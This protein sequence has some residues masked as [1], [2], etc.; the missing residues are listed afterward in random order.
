MDFSPDVKIEPS[1][2]ANL[3]WL[4][5]PVTFLPFNSIVPLFV[6]FA[7]CVPDAGWITIPIVSS[8]AVDPP[9][10]FPLF[11]ISPP[12]LA[13]IPIAFF[14]TL[15]KRILPAV[16]FIA[17]AL[18]FITVSLLTETVSVEE[19]FETIPIFC[20]PSVIL[21]FPLF[22]AVG[23]NLAEL[24]SVLLCPK[25]TLIPIFFVLYTLIS[26]SL[27]ILS[28]AFS[29]KT[30]PL[31]PSPPLTFIIP[32][33]FTLSL[34]A[35]IVFPPVKLL[36]SITAIPDESESLLTPYTG[37]LGVAGLLSWSYDKVL[38]PFILIVP[39]FETVDDS[40]ILEDIFRP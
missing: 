39:S 32:L 17:T 2:I 27:V 31:L 12:F 7:T 24:S 37:I 1:V 21:I 15:L 22:I 14:D 33:F 23:N 16:S 35:L 25:S 19:L 3:P 36:S 9:F 10:I 18:C 6:P 20:S 11:I 8:R 40:F 34:W 38:S 4:Y 5:T 26:F 30:I 28:L 29:I 13:N